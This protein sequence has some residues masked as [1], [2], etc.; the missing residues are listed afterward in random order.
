MAES[1]SR[2]GRPP[3][4]NEAVALLVLAILCLGANWP[5]LRIAVGLIEPFWL[6]AFRMIAAA[7]IYALF[8]ATRGSLRLPQ[9]GDLPVVLGTGLMQMGV[10]VAAITFGVKEVG[11]GRSAILAYTVPVWVAPGAMLFL[12][13]RITRGQLAGLICGLAGVVVLFNPLG[14]DWSD[15]RVLLGNGAVLG[16]AVVWAAALLQMRGH[17]WR[18]DPLALL[19]WQSL[20][21]ALLLWPLAL[22][23]EGWPPTIRWGWEL[24][25]SFAFIVLFGTCLAFWGLGMAARHLPAIGVSLGQLATPVIGVIGAALFVAETPS[26]S[27][28]AGLGLIIAGVACGSI[29]GRPPAEGAKQR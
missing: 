4:R 5:V 16:G 19:P 17:R 10:I 8:L 15:K 1:S 24:G 20:L 11:A 29:L 21:G 18:A 6:S 7:A 22:L 12:G 2:A 14:F 9:P 28:L 13:E 23:A 3:S 26:Y 25:W 27:S